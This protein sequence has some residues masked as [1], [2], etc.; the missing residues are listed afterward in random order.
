MVSILISLLIL[1]IIGGLIWY[2]IGIIP[3]T[4]QIRT[5]VQVIVGLIFI[6]YLLGMLT[7]QVP[8]LRL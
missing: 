7:G 4:P 1:V 3:M 8:S 5:V 2:I 6:L